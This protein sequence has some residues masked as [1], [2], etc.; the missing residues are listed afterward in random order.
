ML[1]AHFEIKLDNAYYKSISADIGEGSSAEKLNA[2]D[3][4]KENSSVNVKTADGVAGA[5]AD[6]GSAQSL[7]SDAKDSGY[8]GGG[9]GTNTTAVRI[10]RDFHEAVVNSDVDLLTIEMEI[11]GDPFFMADS[12]QGN[13]SA[14]PNPLFKKSLTI[15]N[16]PTHE[17]NEVLMRLNFRTPVD[18]TNGEAGDMEFPEKSQPV[19]TFSGLYKVLQV[20]NTIASGQFKQN[21]RAIR[22]LNQNE[23][24]APNTENIIKEGDKSNSQNNEGSNNMGAR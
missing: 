19:E 15:D 5:K 2:V 11:M 20:Q 13:Y 3:S 17:Q 10:A 21:L 24:I 23:K 14:L 9:R 12:G 4:A 7:Q 16:T 8:S 22:I 6:N 1:K 18:Y